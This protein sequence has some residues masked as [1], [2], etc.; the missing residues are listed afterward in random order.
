MDTHAYTNKDNIY[1]SNNKRNDHTHKS[2]KGCNDDDDAV[3]YI[4]M[5]LVSNKIK[6][7]LLSL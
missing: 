3:L 5:H 4:T 6:T 2:F 7:G 1:N